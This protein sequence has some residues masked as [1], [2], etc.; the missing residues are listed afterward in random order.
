MG[1]SSLEN[2]V[3]V[4]VI[5]TSA[6]GV[7]ALKVLL[8]TLPA[9]LDALLFAVLHIAPSSPGFLADLLSKPGQLRC[10]HP[11]QGEKSQPGRFYLAP[12][13]RHMLVEAQG[14][15]RLSHGP[16][17]NRVRPAIDPL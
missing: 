12:P 16:K 17:E 3:R 11:S 9:D 1:G 4:I 14:T 10:V 2:P 6:G 13:D 5:G 7:Q 15:I 8:V